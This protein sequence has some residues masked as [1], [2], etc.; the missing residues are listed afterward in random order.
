V[1]ALLGQDDDSRATLPVM[2]QA[3]THPCWRMTDT[4]LKIVAFERI[5]DVE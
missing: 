2:R 1:L 5:C 3:F 4:A